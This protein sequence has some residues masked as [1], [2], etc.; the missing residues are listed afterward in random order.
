MATLVEG[1]K[2]GHTAVQASSPIAHPSSGAVQDYT[3]IWELLRATLGYNIE[4]LFEADGELSEV[5][6]GGVGLGDEEA[7]MKEVWVV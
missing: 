2:L 4:L 7:E 5:M 1:P 6:T 3:R